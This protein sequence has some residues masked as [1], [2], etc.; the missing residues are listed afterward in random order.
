[1]TS[2]ESGRGLTERIRDTFLFNGAGEEGVLLSE[3]RICRM[4]FASSSFDELL[5]FLFE[6]ILFQ[7]F[8]ATVADDMSF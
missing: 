7:S 1:M 2:S 4:T 5:P 8:N 6:N 3:S